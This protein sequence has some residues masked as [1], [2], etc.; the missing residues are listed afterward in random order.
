MSY[1]NLIYAQKNT[2]AFTYKQLPSSTISNY[3]NS[4]RL[5]GDF[6]NGINVSSYLKGNESVAQRTKVIQDLL[7]SNKKIILPNEKLVISVEGLSLNSN[8]ELLFQKNSSLV[9]ESNNLS[10]YQLLKVHN[11]N[12]IKIYNANLIGDRK[13]HQGNT[14]EWGY[15]ISIRNSSNVIIENAIINDF[16]G[17]GIAIGYSNSVT[18]HSISIKNVYLDNNRRNGISVMNVNGLILDCICVSNTN[19]TLPMFG[20]DFEPNNSNDNLNNI[21]IKNVYSYNNQMGGLMITFNNLKPKEI[22][23]INFKISN[24][25]DKYS[26]EGILI[27][28]IPKEAMNLKGTIS[29]SNVSLNSNARPL[30]GRTIYNPSVKVIINDLSVSNP[31]NKKITH[32]EV[33]RVFKTKKNYSIKFKN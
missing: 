24:F 31:R 10:T 9:M 33:D 12:N 3:Y 2:E 4:S 26:Y 22:K 14:G 17:D 29:L 25:S 13:T 32:S 27:A 16:W 15:G 21:V 7:N 19:G 8:N 1:I 6:S 18:S 5:I 11:V 20:L 23:N 30:T 28:G